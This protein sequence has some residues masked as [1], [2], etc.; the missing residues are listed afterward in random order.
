M[1]LLCFCFYHLPPRGQKARSCPVCLELPVRPAAFLKAPLQCT[2]WLPGPPNPPRARSPR[3]AEA[4]LR[5]AAPEQQPKLPCLFVLT[6]SA[7]RR[8]P[9]STTVLS[10]LAIFTFYVL[11]RS[12]LTKLSR[13]MEERERQE[14][15]AA[16]S[17][18]GPVTAGGGDGHQLPTSTA[19]AG[20]SP[21]PHKRNVAVD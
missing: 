4:A 19:A 14:A 11:E 20:G 21:A 13:W 3:A 18:G 15:A 5:C 12:V 2:T 8:P 10:R 9:Q 16:G 17:S 7:T 6:F 1:F